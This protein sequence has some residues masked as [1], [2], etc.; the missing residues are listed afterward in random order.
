[1]QLVLACLIVVCASVFM[2]ELKVSVQ[3]FDGEGQIERLICVRSY[4]SQLESQC[5]EN[6]DLLQ[7]TSESRKQVDSGNA[8]ARVQR[9]LKPAD[10][11]DI[12]FCTR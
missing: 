8:L 12:T 3:I 11:W 10:L 4:D 5:N 2:L 9:V 1:M 7:I 6:T